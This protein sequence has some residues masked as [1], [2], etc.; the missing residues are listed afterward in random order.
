MKKRKNTFKSQ[1]VV[2][3]VEVVECQDDANKIFIVLNVNIVIK[4]VA[5]SFTL[6]K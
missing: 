2:E 3:V 6:R 1:W 4:K 5:L